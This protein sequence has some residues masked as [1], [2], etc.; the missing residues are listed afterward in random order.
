MFFPFLCVFIVIHLFLLLLFNKF[1]TTSSFFINFCKYSLN[2]YTFYRHKSLR[3]LWSDFL[4]ALWC[5][6][7]DMCLS[8]LLFSALFLKFSQH[9]CIHLMLFL[10]GI[11]HHWTGN[12][13][14]SS[15]LQEAGVG[16]GS[17]HNSGQHTA[18]LPEVFSVLIYVRLC[19]R[20]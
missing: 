9:T 5:F 15:S 10:F 12:S 2:V 8:V 18:V 14:C 17:G 11:A 20:H 13:S 3:G 1:T 6:L 7:S 4:L 19:P 16:K